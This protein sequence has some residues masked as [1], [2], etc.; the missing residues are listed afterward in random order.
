MT[1]KPRIGIIISTTRATRFA[2]KPTEW[3]LD[4]AR[5]LCAGLAAAHRQGV[6]HRDLK[7]A[8][9]LIDNHGRAIITDFGIAITRAD[10]SPHALIGTP[11]YMAPEQLTPG[12][13]LT[14]CTD[15]YALGLILYELVVGQH[16]FNN[17]LTRPTEP[18][19]PSSRVTGVDPRLERVI[20]QALQL[21]PRNRPQSAA[22]MGR[23]PVR[24]T[25]PP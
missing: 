21:D 18:V 6:L 24:R 8:N 25:A 3:F 20:L 16:P 13:T 12:A 19:S 22:A 7:P 4:I 5:Q 14:E 17:R 11:G 10:A 9:I 15:I 1:D 2:D 23:W